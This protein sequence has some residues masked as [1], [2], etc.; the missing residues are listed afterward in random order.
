MG[1]F[2]VSPLCSIVQ[3]E[4]PVEFINRNKTPLSMVQFKRLFT[5]YRE[6]HETCD[7]LH[8]LEPLDHITV[9]RRQQYYSLPVYTTD[10]HGVKQ[11]LCSRDI[12]A[13]LHQID[14]DS[15]RDV[16]QYGVG[17]LTSEERP[18]WARLRADLLR[19]T[20]NKESLQSIERSLFVVTLDQC[21]PSRDFDKYYHNT[22][23]GDANNRWFDK[24]F[25]FIVYAD[26]EVGMN[27]R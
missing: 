13:L 8:V 2:L 14:I 22:L 24:A 19:D 25:N 1:R 6:P 18:V 7:I 16:P 15:Q 26:G 21:D 12:E 10:K 11:R 5:T 3:E 27:G 20:T 9:I 17:V 23:A 4:V